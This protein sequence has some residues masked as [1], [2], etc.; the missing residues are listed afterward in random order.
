MKLRFWLTIYPLR[1]EGG[2]KFYAQTALD[3]RVTFIN[4]ILVFIASGK[5]WVK[6]LRRDT[7][8]SGV[9]M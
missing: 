4:C 7:F 8:P 6:N 5:E 1:S 2:T 3:A 9:K